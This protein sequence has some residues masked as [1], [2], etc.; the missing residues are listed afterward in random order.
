MLSAL[1]GSI[2]SAGHK[3]RLGALGGGERKMKGRKC[4][5]AV[6]RSP[7]GDVR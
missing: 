2:R 1:F 4:L 6:D 3:E 5:F 7:G